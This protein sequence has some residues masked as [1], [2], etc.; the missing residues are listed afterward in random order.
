MAQIQP[1][2]TVRLHCAKA[3]ATAEVNTDLLRPFR[4]TS[5]KWYRDRK[6]VTATFLVKRSET[7]EGGDQSTEYAGKNELE[8]QTKNWGKLSTKRL[9]TRHE[10]TGRRDRCCAA[11]ATNGALSASAVAIVAVRDP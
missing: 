9:M 5:A 2:T 10:A 7:S 3:H 6:L 8:I 11:A 1:H 4:L